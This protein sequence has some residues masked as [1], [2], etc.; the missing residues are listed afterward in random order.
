MF[1]WVTTFKTLD[2]SSSLFFLQRLHVRKVLCAHVYSSLVVVNQ[3]TQKYCFDILLQSAIVLVLCV[4]GGACVQ[5]I[6]LPC[7]SVWCVC[8][9]E[10]GDL[11]TGSRYG[12]H[13]T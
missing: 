9:M 8:R 5:V 1:G 2:Y 4:T 13:K 6:K 12:I 7:I 10:G 11:V 3:F